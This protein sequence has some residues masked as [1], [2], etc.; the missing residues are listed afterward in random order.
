[1]M[2]MELTTIYLHYGQL[3]PRGKSWFPLLRM[4]LATWLD[5]SNFAFNISGWN[6]QIGPFHFCKSGT[7]F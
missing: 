6:V 2:N 1:M 5:I 3:S 7:N 4:A